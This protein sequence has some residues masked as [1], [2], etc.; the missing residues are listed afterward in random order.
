M[1]LAGHS[2]PSQTGR[3]SGEQPPGVVLVPLACLR[4]RAVEMPWVLGVEPQVPVSALPCGNHATLGKAQPLRT[5]CLA[6]AESIQSPAQLTSVAL[7]NKL[8]DYSA[9]YKLEADVDSHLSPLQFTT[10][11]IDS[12]V[13]SYQAP[14]MCQ[15]CAESWEYSC[16]QVRWDF[17]IHGVYTLAKEPSDE[18]KT[19]SMT[20]AA[21]TSYGAGVWGRA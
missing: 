19:K 12:F 14:T 21:G 20:S 6:C 10:H 13:Q 4:H 15:V 9:V 2:H 16:E 17:C 7:E 8:S 5:H 18:R 3:V 11:A 1:W